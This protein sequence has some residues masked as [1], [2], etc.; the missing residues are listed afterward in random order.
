MP[1]PTKT[2]SALSILIS[3]SRRAD[4]ATKSS[5]YFR[6][7][8]LSPI[9]NDIRGSLLIPARGTSCVY[10]P[11]GF[12]GFSS[13]FLNW[14]AI[15][16][17]ESSSPFVPGERPS[18]SFDA[19]TLMCASNA[20]GVIVSSAGCKRNAS[21][22]SERSDAPAA[23]QTIAVSSR[24]IFVVYANVV[25]RNDGISR[26]ARLE[27]ALLQLSAFLRWPCRRFLLLL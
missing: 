20:S 21:S 6:S 4:E 22:S 3:G 2:T 14:S 24:V 17:T 13:I 19:R 26:G 15:Y 10:V 12:P 25:E 9:V 18:N 11:S 5:V 16:L 7:V 8:V 23:K 1:Y 27:R